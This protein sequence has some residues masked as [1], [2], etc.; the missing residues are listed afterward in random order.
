M[1]KLLFIAMAFVSALCSYAQNDYSLEQLT[2]AMNC[3][4]VKMRASMD[5]ILSDGTVVDNN[6]VVNLTLVYGGKESGYSSD[7]YICLLYE[8]VDGNDC[9]ECKGF[10]DYPR[11][12]TCSGDDDKV[13]YYN[14]VIGNGLKMA[15]SHL[16][17]HHIEGSG[18]D[19]LHL[20]QVVDASGKAASYTIISCDFYDISSGTER[21]VLKDYI[22]SFDHYKDRN[23]LRVF[24]DRM[25][26]FYE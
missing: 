10:M 2:A 23:L 20:I 11:S 18:F 21:L 9:N 6:E 14:L 26:K 25:R 15:V 17:K 24:A 22:P 16:D 8:G 19:S 7:D 5:V 3:R 4:L 13:D 1:K 12:V